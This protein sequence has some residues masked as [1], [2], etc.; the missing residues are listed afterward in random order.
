VIRGTLECQRIE[1]K[2]RERGDKSY[3]PP[4][5]QVVVGNDGTTSKIALLYKGL[6]CGFVY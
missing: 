1:E 5:G 2:K 4:F 6:S 3:N